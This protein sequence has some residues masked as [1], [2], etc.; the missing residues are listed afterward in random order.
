MNNLI[1]PDL[2]EFN[3]YSSARDEA[4]QGKIWLN[5]NESPYNFELQEHVLLNRYP[6]KQPLQL[7]KLFS[8]LYHVKENQI[9]LSR[10][11]DEVID[12]LIRLFCSAGK[13]AILTCPPTFG[14]Y[15]VCAKL[16]NA[17]V[18]EVPLSQSSGYQLDLNSIISS[19]TP[20]V[21]IIFLCS[22]NNP[23]GNLL[24]QDDILHLC[25]TFANKSIVVVDE[26]YIEY[27]DTT[28]LS[29]YINEYKNLVILR[30]LS[31][32]YGLAGLRCGFLLAAEEL[33]RWILKIIAPYP[34]PSIII[35]MISDTLSSARLK[36]VEQ[37]IQ[38]VRS[39]R[40][41]L[42]EALKKM[43]FVKKI[44]PSKANFVLVEMQDAETI[45]HQCSENGIIL[46]SMC[47]KPGLENCLRISIGLPEENT[48][49]INLLSTLRHSA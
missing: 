13:D 19:W 12:L 10:G 16:Q 30:T 49:L 34:L 27:A 24:Q 42:E 3:A 5:A 2:R 22:P 6:E 46:R 38:C 26:A 25:K 28:S 21:K 31:K 9:V 43:S 45:M 48:Q 11:S 15:A 44:W 35:K 40:T 39:E 18:I 33:V 4:K 47:N 23:T 20:A 32:A 37:Q 29:A 8:E 41:R 1:R 14:M 17:N 36:Q 7:I